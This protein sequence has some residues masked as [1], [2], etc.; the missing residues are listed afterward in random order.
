MSATHYRPAGHVHVQPRY[1]TTNLREKLNCLSHVA[2]Q[3][4]LGDLA[5]CEVNKYAGGMKIT[6]LEAA[7]MILLELLV[8]TNLNADD[9]F[10]SVLVRMRMQCGLSCLMSPSSLG[11]ATA[12]E[13]LSKWPSLHS[14][15]GHMSTSAVHAAGLMHQELCVA[16]EHCR[17]NRRSDLDSCFATNKLSMVLQS[18]KAQ[19]PDI[20]VAVGRVVEEEE[21]EEEAVAEAE[22][23][24]EV[25]DEEAEA[26]EAEAVVDMDEVLV[27]SVEQATAN[28]AALRVAAGQHLHEAVLQENLTDALGGGLGDDAPTVNGMSSSL[29]GTATLKAA[30]AAATHMQQAEKLMQAADVLEDEMTAHIVPTA[31]GLH[32]QRMHKLRAE[33]NGGAQADEANG[34]DQAETTRKKENKEE[35]EDDGKRKVCGQ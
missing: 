29:T 3:E 22:R 32:H 27:T 8:M 13:A 23:I 26:A 10:V 11:P 19:L 7:T 17:N 28:A 31:I 5:H 25:R 1:D 24:Q 21:E 33:A 9:A 20:L 2:N 6:L 4:Q 18:L 35:E 12:D 14:G 30:H 16:A 34:G 15:I